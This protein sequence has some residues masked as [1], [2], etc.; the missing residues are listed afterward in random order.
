MFFKILPALS[1]M[2]CNIRKIVRSP[3]SLCVYVCVHLRVCEIHQNNKLLT[4]ALVRSGNCVEFLSKFVCDTSKWDCM[5]NAVAI[6]QFFSG[7]KKCFLDPF[8]ENNFDSD[9][10]CK[11]LIQKKRGM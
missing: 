6:A 7:V 10:S 1:R 5:L 3:F 9:A 8:E 2:I 4:A 11:Q